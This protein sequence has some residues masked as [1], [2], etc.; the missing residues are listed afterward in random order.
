ML[1]KTEPGAGGLHHRDSDVSNN[2]LMLISDNSDAFAARELAAREAV[3]S[4]DLMY[5]AWHNDNCGRALLDEVVEAANRGVVVR[6][7]IDDINPHR[8]D[9]IYLALDDTPNISVKLFNPSRARGRGLARLLEMIGRMRAMTR[10]M[11]NK[12]WI[13]DRSRAIIGGRN[14]GNE[15]FDAAETNFRDLDLLIEGPVVNE[16]CAVFDGYWN[17]E[18]SVSVSSLHAMRQRRIRR[19]FRRKPKGEIPSPQSKAAS[20]AALI[21]ANGGLELVD[22]VRV[23]ADPP[24][25]VMEREEGNWLMKQVAPIFEAAQSQA[26]VVSPYFIPGDEGLRIVSG[27]VQRGVAT[28]VLTNSLAATDVAAVHGAYATYRRRLLKHG[29]QLYEL[30]P[31]DETQRMSVFGSKGASLHTKAFAVDDRIGF[32]GSLNFDPRSAAL[33]AEMGV[34]FEDEQ[35][36]RKLVA[37]IREQLSPRSSYHVTLQNGLLTWEGGDEAKRCHHEPEASVWRRLVAGVIRWLP[38]ESQL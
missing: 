38:M 19:Y 7:L 13:V 36:T 33:N 21:D 35:I 8:S 22:N 28:T 12:A 6:L 37:L 4:L 10:R 14:I 15:Y 24:D 32:V 31:Y 18:A 30:Q 25:K 11:H 20:L 17:H 1:N 26:H 29:V 27:M 9:A 34:L 5:Y 23:V 16:A 3:R 2:R